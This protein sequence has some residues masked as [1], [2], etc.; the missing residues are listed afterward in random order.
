M[1][2]PLAVY[3]QVACQLAGIPRSC[4]RYRF[5]NAEDRS[6][7]DARTVIAGD[8]RLQCYSAGRAD[9]PV[10][11]CAAHPADAFL[12]PTAERLAGHAQAR[13]VCINPRG[14][15]ASLPASQASF[16]QMVD[17]IELAR[18]RLELGRIVF[19]GMSGGGW[20]AQLYARRYPEAL[21]GIIIDSV[22][23]CFR[24]RLFDP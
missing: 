16:E 10:T 4:Y 20:L 13:V 5:P 23:A 9:S 2:P 18:R 6:M 15:G 1:A 11:V 7:N 14:V 22:C 17:D 21:E 12:G 24:A 19:W 3:E 8:A